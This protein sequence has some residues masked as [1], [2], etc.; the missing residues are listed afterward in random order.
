SN[1]DSLPLSTSNLMVSFTM[2]GGF[3]SQ[4]VLIILQNKSDGI[5]EVSFY[6]K[7]LDEWY[8]VQISKEFDNQG[9][10]YGRFVDVF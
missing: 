1:E 2:K 6:N 9:N 10:S 5:T 3:F 4:L 7:E 8:D